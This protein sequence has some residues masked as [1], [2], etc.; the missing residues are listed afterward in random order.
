MHSLRAEFTTTGYIY[1]AGQERRYEYQFAPIKKN[2]VP[3]V[4][5]EYDK[6]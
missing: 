4:V 5:N 1:F 3:T 2:I 6:M